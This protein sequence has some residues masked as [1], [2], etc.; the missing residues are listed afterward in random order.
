[1]GH[2]FPAAPV[3]MGL[4]MMAGT[5][6]ADCDAPSVGLGDG[7]ADCDGCPEM[8]V[9]P[10]RSFLM[11]S[12]DDEDGRSAHEGPRHMVHIGYTFA[13]GRHEVT[14]AQWDACVDAGGCGHRARDAGWGRGNMPVLDVTW[15][16]ARAYVAWLDRR[17][18]KPYRLPSEAEWEFAAR[19]GATTAYPWVSDTY[20]PG[21][22]NCNDGDGE[23]RPAEV[24]TF[25]ANGAGLHDM[26]GNVAEWVED[27]WHD[28]YAGA[29][30][31]GG[32]WTD[33]G[34]RWRVARG[35]SWADPP[36]ARPPPSPRAARSGLATS[37]WPRN[38]AR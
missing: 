38:G 24:G 1:M 22:V 12:P 35:G 30:D 34:C 32:A 28:G 6:L 10:T 7:C 20:A 3:F 14:F 36:S 5:A 33:G 15:H 29:P 18:G 11:G 2:P 27:C 25:P 26:A 8:V 31:D 17:T 16:D 4:L 9:M 37:G 13:I 21:M 23:G 19:A